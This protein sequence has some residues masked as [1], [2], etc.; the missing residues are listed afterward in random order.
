MSEATYSHSSFSIKWEHRDV[1][2]SVKSWFC[3]SDV[4]EFSFR[5][6]DKEL[7]WPSGTY[8]ALR[9]AFRLKLNRSVGWDVGS[10]PQSEALTQA[11]AIYK[12]GVPLKGKETPIQSGTYQIEFIDTWNLDPDGFYIFDGKVAEAWGITDSENTLVIHLDEKNKNLTTVAKL[13]TAAFLKPVSKL[14]GWTFVGGG[15]LGDLGGFAATIAGHS[16]RFVPTTLLSM[17]DACIGGKTGVNFEEF[18]KNQ[19]G[20]FAFPQKVVIAKQWLKTLPTREFNAGL[21]EAFKHALLSGNKR[22][23]ESAAKARPDSSDF[24]PLIPEFVKVKSDIVSI[25]PI[26]QGLRASLNLGHTLAHAIERLSHL[27]SENPIHHGEAVGVGLLF[28][29]KLSHS[30]G[31]LPLSPYRDMYDLLIN[32]NF[33]I[34]PYS[35]AQYLN[36]QNLESDELIKNILE[37]ISLDKKNSFDQD[38]NWILLSDWGSLA[39]PSESEFTI[40]VKNHEIQTCYFEFLREWKKH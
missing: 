38:S 9:Y 10:H 19:I 23:A 11:A 14:N 3:W 37:G 12:R 40:R 18:G 39:Q 8:E 32:S 33:L 31:L 35:L 30:M 7:N 16:F 21:S 13:L 36:V 28:C 22:L 2:S 26:E 34:T 20:S 29:I 17:I 4:E 6:I 24:F 5:P 1:C 15:V 25:D 27:N